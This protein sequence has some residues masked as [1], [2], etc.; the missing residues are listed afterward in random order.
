M[1][2]RE[3][4]IIRFTRAKDRRQLKLLGKSR[5]EGEGERRDFAGKF[6]NGG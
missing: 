6:V 5:K 2:P 3:G 4:R 1:R